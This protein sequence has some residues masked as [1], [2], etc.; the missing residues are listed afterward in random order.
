M[1][2]IFLTIL[3]FGLLSYLWLSNFIS[4]PLSELIDATQQIAQSG[5]LERRVVIK[6]KDEIGRLGVAFNEMITVRKQVEETLQ[7]ERDLA[8][9]LE[10]AI[11]TLGTTLDFEKVLDLILEQVSRVVPNDSANIMLIKGE[12]AYISRS[13]G[14]ERYGLE[15][16]IS[17]AVF[18]VT[19]VASFK[20]YV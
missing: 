17:K 9:A 4:K 6:S 3:L 7:K 13:R 20:K 2:S 10:E 18:E 1:I 8:K 15:D 11:A 14:Y 12:K 5:K 19:E 16:V